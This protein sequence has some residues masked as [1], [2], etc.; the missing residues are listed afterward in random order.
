MKFFLKSGFSRVA[1]HAT[2]EYTP[3]YAEDE[4][5]PLTREERIKFERG[6]KIKDINSLA[7]KR[8]PV[9]SYRNKSK[10]ADKWKLLLLLGA[11]IADSGYLL[12]N[13]EKGWVH[14]AVGSVILLVL[15]VF[16]IST[17]KKH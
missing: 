3:R 10:K 4:D 12:S 11:I 14:I 8:S 5:A 16:F 9:L 7:N 2:F 13:M 17:Q 1:K 15:L 6:S